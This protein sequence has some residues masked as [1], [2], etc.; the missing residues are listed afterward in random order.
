MLSIQLCSGTH[1]DPGMDM[2]NEAENIDVQA[3]ARAR[4]SDGT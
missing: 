3:D 1:A 4:V 2:K